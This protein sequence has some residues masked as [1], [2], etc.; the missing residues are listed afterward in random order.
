MTD[1]EIWVP[2]QVIEKL[3]A[4]QQAARRRQIDRLV[5]ELQNSVD[6]AVPRMA[7]VASEQ[8]A[9][10][11]TAAIF[12]LRAN[13]LMREVRRASGVMLQSLGLRSIFELLAVGRFL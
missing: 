9:R 2:P 3:A 1:M 7:S 4:E 10:E 12:L 6:A 13:E 8:G 5:D 11:M